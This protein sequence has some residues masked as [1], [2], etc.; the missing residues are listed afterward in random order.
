MVFETTYLKK[1]LDK[2]LNSKHVLEHET[3]QVLKN[4]ENTHLKAVEE[5]E[6][7]YERKLAFENEKFLQQEQKLYELTKKYE[8]EIN[9]LQQKHDKNI[10]FL[11]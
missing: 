7:L 1:E 10:I 4:I 5:L 11:K 2:A 8:K 9:N 6:N 3:D